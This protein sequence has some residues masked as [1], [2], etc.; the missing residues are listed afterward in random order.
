MVINVVIIG[1]IIQSS[2]NF[3]TASRIR[4]TKSAE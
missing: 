1:K 3:S 2:G 4:Y